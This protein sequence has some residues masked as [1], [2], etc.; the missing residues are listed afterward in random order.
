MYIIIVN[1]H[2]CRGESQVETTDTID[3]NQLGVMCMNANFSQAGGSG[4]AK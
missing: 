4:T 2:K 1:T 3:Y